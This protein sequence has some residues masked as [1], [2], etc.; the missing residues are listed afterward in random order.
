MTVATV[1]TVAETVREN[2]S[3]WWQQSLIVVPSMMFVLRLV[4]GGEFFRRRWWSSGAFLWLVLVG[5]NDERS[6]NLQCIGGLIG[7]RYD[8]SSSSFNRDTTCRRLSTTDLAMAAVVLARSP[9]SFISGLASSKCAKQHPKQWK[10][11]IKSAKNGTAT[12]PSKLPYRY[13]TKNRQPPPVRERP[14]RACR[15][16]PQSSR[17]RNSSAAFTPMVGLA[18]HCPAGVANP[19]TIRKTLRLQLP[20]PLPPPAV[21]MLPIS[22]P[23]SDS[24]HHTND[25]AKRT[26]GI[27][28]ARH[29]SILVGIKATVG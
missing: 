17:T 13:F 8:S 27:S 19:I 10:K 11:E 28:H 21:P 15:Q 18:C 24:S 7:C 6:S 14:R 20:P 16:P 1:A 5:D 22:R 12:K 4:V 2:Q 9:D 3:D 29:N 26:G 23:C 25:K